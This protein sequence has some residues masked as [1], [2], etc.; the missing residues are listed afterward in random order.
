MENNKPLER[1]FI[2]SV[3]RAA[4]RVG[5]LEDEWEELY[6]SVIH[7]H[8]ISGKEIGRFKFVDTVDGDKIFIDEDDWWKKC[9]YGINL[10]DGSF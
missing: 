9:G 7:L 1:H 6:G 4:L 5:V 10:D 8:Q 2:V 3:L